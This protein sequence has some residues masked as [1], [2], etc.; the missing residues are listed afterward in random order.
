MNI[1]KIFNVSEDRIQ[2]IFASANVA[3]KRDDCCY[4]PITEIAKGRFL[5]NLF[6][7]PST[8]TRLSFDV[9]MKSLGGE[10]ITVGKQNSSVQKGE[11]LNDTL[12]TVAQYADA[13][14]LRTSENIN[15][16]NFENIPIP[17]INAGDGDGEHPTQALID[18]YTIRNYFKEHFS[19]LFLGDLKYG[20]TIHSLIQ[21]LS[22]YDC[23]IYHRCPDNRKLPI[24]LRGLSEDAESNWATRIFPDVDVVYCTREQTERVADMTSGY[25]VPGYRTFYGLYDKQP[26]IL[27][28][29][30][31]VMHPFPRGGEIP[32]H[33]DQDHR[34]KYFEQA[35]NGVYVRIGILM[36]VLEIECPV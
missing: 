32:K 36:D 16:D 31:I 24:G 1:L 15:P 29:D 35:K 26:N 11:S 20:R 22:R 12:M 4:H 27:K 6:F 17:I 3:K 21:L 2:K 28:E 25:R 8:R 23:K 19:I 33:W 34:A 30:A 7:E 18:L 9:A 10:V 14:V 5:A 13:I